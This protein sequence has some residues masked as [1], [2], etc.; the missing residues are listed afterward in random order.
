MGKLAI[1]CAVEIDE[2]NRPR[3]IRAAPIADYTA[4]TLGAFVRANVA[5]RAVLRTDG[6]PSYR[7]LAH[8][9]E[10][11]RHAP[12]VV[13]PMAGHVLLKWVHRV[14]SNAK[15]WFTGTLHGV[16]RPHL[17]RYLDEFVFRWNRRRSFSSAF[18]RLV[19][20]AANLR[21][22]TFRDLVDH[23]ASRS[24]PRHDP[25]PSRV[26]I[27]TTP[28]LSGR[29]SPQPGPGT[30]LRARSGQCLGD[31]PWWHLNQLEEPF[32]K[33][34]VTLYGGGLFLPLSFECGFGAGRVSSQVVRWSEAGR[35]LGWAG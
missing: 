22:A 32:R 18:D 13:G 29:S 24:G 23:V 7:A 16:R 20:L 4:D 19:Q 12:R 33:C 31:Y 9:P 28:D 25:A 2:D 10:G 26:A 27:V 15:R 6:N 34:A 1:V 30:T 14:I 11:Y 21:P 35:K 17:Q 5:D 8:G 3:R